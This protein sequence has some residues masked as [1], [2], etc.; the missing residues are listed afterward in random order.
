MNNSFPLSEF[1][2]FRFGYRSIVPRGSKR[3]VNCRLKL[4]YPLSVAGQG[5]LAR[6]FSFIRNSNNAYA[7]I[8]P[9]S[10]DF[11]RLYS[12]RASPVTVLCFSAFAETGN[13][14]S[15]V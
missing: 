5:F 12:E 7:P 6:T 4:A 9:F 2:R 11:R 14:N 3:R 8:F 13:K 10:V 15:E 1:L